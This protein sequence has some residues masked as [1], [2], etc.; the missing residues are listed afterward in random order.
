MGFLQR[1]IEKT[2]GIELFKDAT[3]Q[4]KRKIKN[5]RTKEGALKRA[6]LTL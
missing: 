2:E 1:N 6:M 3:K 4:K 5:R